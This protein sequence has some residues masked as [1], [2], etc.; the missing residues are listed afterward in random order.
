[1][2]GAPVEKQ[3]RSLAPLT[4]CALRRTTGPRR[5]GSRDD[6]SVGRDGSGR[7]DAERM[8]R[9]CICRTRAK[10]R[11]FPSHRA[12]TRMRDGWG[13]RPSCQSQVVGRKG[14]A[15]PSSRLPIARSGAQRVPDVRVLGM[16]PA[17]KTERRGRQMG[18]RE[19]NLVSMI[20]LGAIPKAIAFRGRMD[21]WQGL[22]AC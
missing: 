22:A 18:I 19:T 2:D 1:M 6:T 14:E 21:L 11:C 13:T 12:E 10:V 16:T 20:F 15:D 17:W 3:S 9:G 7:Q 5:A 8:Q 4:H